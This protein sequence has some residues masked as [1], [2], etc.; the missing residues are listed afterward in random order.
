MEADERYG[1]KTAKRN[2]WRMKTKPKKA[3]IEEKIISKAELKAL[4]AEWLHLAWTEITS[5]H[6]VREEKAEILPE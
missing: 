3:L 6:S 4:A 2:I 1:N 5:F